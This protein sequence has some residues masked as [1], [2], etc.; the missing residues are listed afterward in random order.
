MSILRRVDRKKQ[1]EKEF[2]M[3]AD[4]VDVGNPTYLNLFRG[5]LY[6]SRGP[7]GIL[8]HPHRTD[9]DVDH[10]HFVRQIA[11]HSPESRTILG[12]PALAGR[13]EDEIIDIVEFLER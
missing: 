6:V 8:I 7:S 11:F 1:L 12:S 5:R 4:F 10:L 9:P 13:R 2:W 3:C